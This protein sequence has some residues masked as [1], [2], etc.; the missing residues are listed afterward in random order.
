[1]L[2]RLASPRHIVPAHRFYATAASSSTPQTLIE[3]IVQKYAVGAGKTKVRSGDYV[4]VG[5]EHV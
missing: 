4:M 1:M 2:H 5:P 3:K